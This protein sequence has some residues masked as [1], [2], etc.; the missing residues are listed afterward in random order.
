MS[1]PIQLL[2][3]IDVPDLDAATAFYLDLAVPDVEVA[4]SAGCQRLGLMARWAGHGLSS[5]RTLASLVP[6][7]DPVSQA[8]GR[9]C[10]PP[11]FDRK[12]LVHEGF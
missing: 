6:G 9:K 10:F 5:P 12:A 3:T 1:G 11:T 7:S 4:R 8:L 2:V